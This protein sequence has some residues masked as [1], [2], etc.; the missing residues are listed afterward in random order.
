M[1]NTVVGNIQSNLPKLTTYGT[2]QNGQLREVVNLGNVELL[3]KQR[4]I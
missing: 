2:G 4:I 1:N 3:V